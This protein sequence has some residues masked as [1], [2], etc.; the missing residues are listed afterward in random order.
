MP[1]VVAVLAESPLDRLHCG[2]ALRSRWMGLRRK[3]VTDARMRW[4]RGN[5]RNLLSKTTS[6]TGGRRLSRRLTLSTG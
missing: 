6:R 4:K 5:M 3:S 1:V 2:H